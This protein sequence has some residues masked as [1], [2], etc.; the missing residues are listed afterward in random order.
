MHTVHLAVGQKSGFI[1]AAMGIMFSVDSPTPG[2]SAS[3]VAI[4]DEFF[5][6]LNWEKTSG[7][8]PLVEKV[9][10][11]KLMMMFDMKN[12]WTYKGSVT[13]PPCA[14]N[15]YWNVLR[16]IYP[17]KQ[18]YVDQFKTQLAREPGLEKTGNWR[19][20]LPLT[21]DHNPIVLFS[22][23]G[24]GAPTNQAAAAASTTTTP[25]AGAAAS[26]TPAAA[27]SSGSSGQVQLQQQGTIIVQHQGYLSSGMPMQYPQPQ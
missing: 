15:V 2:V 27:S 23:E 9:P 3:D 12:R 5:D 4:I 25:A 6:S 11:G 21:D 17:I 20:T 16:T 26:T 13:T 19:V 18:K 10:Y 24:T 8:N 22:N 14:Q 1:A 7:T